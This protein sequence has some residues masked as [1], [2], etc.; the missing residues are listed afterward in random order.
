MGNST[1]QEKL[2]ITPEAIDLW[3]GIG[4]HFDTFTQVVCEFLDNS[5]S[6]Y[7][8]NETPNRSILLKI[9]EDSNSSVEVSIEDAG[10]GIQN[11][12]SSLTLG[13]KD[14][15]ETPL[16]EHG[17]GLKHALASADPN[18]S[19]WKILTRTEDDFDDGKYK[20]ISHKYRY[21]PE[22]EI[23]SDPWPG[24]FNGSG[25][26]VKFRTKKSFFNTVQ[27][28]IPGKANFDTC[29]RYL[30]EDLGWIYKGLIERGL[31][32]ITIISNALDSNL[33]V[34]ALEPRWVGEYPP[35]QGATMKDL[36]AGEIEIKYRFGDIEDSDYAR[37]YKTTIRNSGVEIRVNGRVLMNNIFHDIWRLMPNNKWN[38]FLV[39]VDLISDN[40]D[41]LPKTRTSKNGIRSGDEKLLAL[42]KWIQSVC[43]DPPSRPSVHQTE[44]SLVRDLAKKKEKHIRAED[45][46]IKPEFEVFKSFDSP[47]KVDLYLFDGND[48]VL[49]EAKKGKADAQS[50]YQLIMYWDGAVEDGIEPK[51]GILLASDFSPVIERLIQ[52]YSQMKDAEGNNYVIKKKKWIDEDMQLR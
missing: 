8:A 46:I 4:G 33:T 19:S 36:G 2:D 39:I 24:E 41:R 29:L 34:S 31:V 51:E 11:L 25:T 27:K 26:L 12:R 47:V 37:H 42:Y 52:R 7:I 13:N 38:N 22:P 21:D 48:V 28:G 44:R 30:S 23:I 10:T 20:V 18:N 6:N 9:D 49:Y 3:S 14:S 1:I 35:G 40:I 5:I 17:F 15:R 50:F 16:N 45:K 43:P 32:S